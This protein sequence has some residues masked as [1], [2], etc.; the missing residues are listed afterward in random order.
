VTARKPAREPA[1]DVRNGLV[2][3]DGAAHYCI[4]DVDEMA[5]FLMSIVSD[6]DRWMFVSSSGALT[7][8]RGDASQALFPYVTDDRLHATGGAVGP[9][10]L[11]RVEHPR[12]P[13][14][15]Q[16]FGTRRQPNVRRSLAKSV[17]GDSVLFEDRHDGLGLTV[18]YRWS[19]AER[20]GFVRTTTVVNDGDEPITVGVLDGLVDVLPFGLDPTV[21]QRLSNLTQAYKRSELIDAATRLAVYSLE[22]PVSDQAEPEEVLRATAAWSIG[23]DGPISVGAG[24][25]AEFG[26]G[27]QPD[28]RHLVTGAPGAYLMRATLTIPAGES[29]T[30][31]LVADVGL[32]QSDVVELRH[33]LA[34][35]DDVRTELEAATRH[36]GERLVGIMAPADAQQ[37]TG[38]AI[39][40][41][42][43]FA[44]VTNNVMRGGVPLAG[45]RLDIADVV[46]FLDTRNRRVAARHRR[47]FAELAPT[48]ER[49]ELLDQVRSLDDAHLLR[50][51]D[52][53]L[54]FSFSR[55]HGDPSRP[56][57][58]FS[59]R[60]TDEENRPIVHYEGNWRDVFQ[61]WEALCTSFP[62][63]LPGVITTFVDA[64]TADGHNPYRITRDGIDWEV[65]DPDDP[66]SNIGYWGDH[67]IV[68]LLRLLEAADRY[69]P[70][71]IARRLDERRYTHADV[72]YRIAPYDRLVVDP[73]ATIR[74]D[75][76]ADAR[77]RARVDE[78][79]GDGRL[80]VDA[81]GDIVLVTLLEKLLISALAKL[82]NLVPG[83]G[84]WMNTQRPEWNDANNALVGEGLSMV[85]LFHLR[86]YLGHL[87]D[88][89]TDHFE[90]SPTPVPV[91]TEV[92]AWL[93]SVTE[94]FD[95]VA[96]DPESSDAD[97]RRRSIVDRLGRAASEYREGIYGGGFSGATESVDGDDLAH[98]CDVAIAQL[99]STIRSSW[100]TDGLVHS[101]NLIRFDDGT[102]GAA[103]IE[104]LA[105]M[106]EG[107]VAALGSG[108]LTVEQ[109]ADLLDAL[110]ASEL[111]RPD[112]GSFLLAPARRPP[113]FLDKNVIADLDVDGN[114]LLAGLA[115]AGERSVV[116]RD[117]DGNL[118]FAPE[119]TNRDALLEA[120]DRLASDE[121]WTALAAEHRQPTVDTYERIFGHR[122]YLG[123]SGSMYAYEG[124]GSIYWHM[125]TKLLL[126]VQ[127]AASEAAAAGS[128]P[129]GI[130]R[131]TAAYWR[132]RDGLGF[133]KS[134]RDFG[135][136]PI[137]PYSHTP[138]HAG[139][140][141]P[142]M[143]GAV[144][145]ELLAR[146]RELGIEV[147][148]GDI[149]IDSLLLREREFLD[150]SETWDLLGLTGAPTT[151][152]LDAGTLGLTVCQVPVIVRATTS[153]PNV[154]IDFD[155]G[156][157]ARRAGNSVG[158]EASAE[159]FRRSGR[160]TRIRATVVSAPSPVP[161][162]GDAG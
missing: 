62:E 110:F 96:F 52:E 8:G 120:L 127:V 53:Y 74:F 90:E 35:G 71:E 43:H 45:A 111:Y 44:N 157:T 107:Q 17:V 48:V 109:K 81:H 139:A 66:W 54:P 91:S 10:T 26:S 152:E 162:S 97:Q 161:R 49:R 108:Q 100:R 135:A 124:I 4:A 39:A 95:T 79:G 145:E 146:R 68:Y 13:R 6:G 94:V 3:I 153:E 65:P 84:I 137:D 55:R 82:S 142:G 37:R 112:Q 7:A 101:Y 29:V 41:A 86:E 117:A 27:L 59:I 147:R 129:D 36:T 87:R 130:R 14:T 1:A 78:V 99:D 40:C 25:D 34:S 24:T 72:P 23:L 93:S 121:S 38:D 2:E 58:Q 73:K 116:R 80:L 126:A 132:I 28:D 18:R 42:H 12:G 51:V 21:Y 33:R 105:A 144:K 16:P 148:D 125:V 75:R 63:Y 143:T 136:V 115:A 57:N 61:N 76:A 151:I 20:F 70:H 140:Q 88:L 47:W 159:V 32:D 106:L 114:P 113:A 104:H 128:Q 31:H 22:A 56:W 154:E 119:L 83:G 149:V 11:L 67:Q 156:T 77:A 92:V 118:R 89:V 102:G 134:A 85:T 46:D 103:G 50:L 19:S 160:I 123:R 60:V 15:W 141:Q 5:P 30:W 155:D 131:L 158:R 64:S 9:L 150:R 98:F 138:A 122:S 133:N 69:L